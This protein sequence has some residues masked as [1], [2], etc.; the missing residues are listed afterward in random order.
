M[1]LGHFC[2]TNLVGD[3]LIL[4]SEENTRLKRTQFELAW[5]AG[6]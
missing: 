2:S 4:P 5:K 6:N 1:A 3:D